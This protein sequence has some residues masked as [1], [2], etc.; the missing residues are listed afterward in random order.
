VRYDV[1]GC[2]RRS[3]ISRRVF[4][5]VRWPTETGLKHHLRYHRTDELDNRSNSSCKLIDVRLECSVCTEKLGH[6]YPS[7]NKDRLKLYIQL[8]LHPKFLSSE[9]MYTPT[10]LYHGAALK[11]TVPER[12]ILKSHFR[13]ENMTF[14]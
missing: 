5:K 11:R 7:A 8:L 12:S 9:V 14:R 3:V 10:Q 4:N 6:F 2:A 1:N 13:Y